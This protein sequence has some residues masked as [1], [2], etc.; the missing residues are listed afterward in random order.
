MAGE[1][2]LEEMDER[3]VVT[4]RSGREARGKGEEGGQN[5]QSRAGPF[6]PFS[7]FCSSVVLL[8]SLL[9]DTAYVEEGRD[10]LGSML[11]RITR[12]GKRQKQM[13]E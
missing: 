5:R 2:R 8:E 11:R 10:D 7:V 13:P 9:L 1:S 4:G 6:L 12:N 3:G